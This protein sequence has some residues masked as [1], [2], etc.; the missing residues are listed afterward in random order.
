M[1]S[2]PVFVSPDQIDPDY[3]H[4]HHSLVVCLFEKARIAFIESAGLSQGEL[5]AQDLWA[6][7][8]EIHIQYLREVKEGKYISTC[9]KISA[10]RRRMQFDQRILDLDGKEVAEAKV[11]IMWF[12]KK[13]GRAVS[14]PENVMK[15]LQQRIQDL[16]DKSIK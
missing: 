12:S 9:D 4:L 15:A 16:F 2:I 10:Q 11:T 8:S 5:F 7:I 14:P 13:A 1:F 3:N 6:V